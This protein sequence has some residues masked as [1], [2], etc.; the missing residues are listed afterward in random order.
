MKLY[1]VNSAQFED[2]VL[3]ET[4]VHKLKEIM[5][6]GEISG[7]YSAVL[8]A[9]PTEDDICEALYWDEEERAFMSGAFDGE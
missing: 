6:N 8:I 5:A 4:A 1:R 9:I 7:G 3:V 2:A